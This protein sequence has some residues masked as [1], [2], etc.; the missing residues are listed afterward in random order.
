MANVYSPPEPYTR[1]GRVPSLV[2]FCLQCI[3]DFPDQVQLPCKLTYRPA[4]HRPPKNFR[5]VDRLLTSALTRRHE[6]P[7]VD[8]DDK[9]NLSR[10]DPRLWV[11]TVQIFDHI[12][13]E[14]RTYTIPLNDEL[15]PLL[16]CVPN[17]ATFSLLTILEL[18]GCL[19]LTD[20]SIT[21]VKGLHTLVAFDASR[22]AISARGIL[23]LARTL[24]ANDSS[25]VTRKLRGP[26]ALRILRVKHCARI[27]DGIY[28]SLSLFPLLSV[29]GA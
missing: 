19:A 6:N 22:T 1:G 4:I 21:D 28:S 29:V 26:W 23:A 16:Q 27:D 25:E 15:L 13:S 3:S 17:T 20:N 12:P 8:M 9:F 11:V 14:L 7:D 24:Q 18:P 5:L 10:L 2:W